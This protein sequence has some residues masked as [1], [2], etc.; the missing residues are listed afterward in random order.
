MY[1]FFF[2]CLCPS[3]P[4]LVFCQVFCWRSVGTLLR[5]CRWAYGRQVLMSDIAIGKNKM[6]FVTQD[7]E[8]FSGQWLGEYKKG[9]DKK[10][11]N[12]EKALSFTSYRYDVL[13]PVK[14]FDGKVTVGICLFVEVCSHSESGSVYE[15]IRLERLPYIHRAVSITMDSKG[16]NFGVLQSDPKTRYVNLKIIYVLHY[17]NIACIS[18]Y[19]V[20]F[21]RHGEH[22]ASV[23]SWAF[24]I[25]LWLKSFCN[26]NFL[27]VHSAVKMLVGK[28]WWRR[29]YSGFMLSQ[30]L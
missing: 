25:M 26:S 23:Q 17:M 7:G 5:Q 12:L 13:W 19:P 1:L 9:M 4:G 28:H 30:V 11:K 24:F 3:F 8:G 18:F 14:W 20:S 27:L 2:F 16:R 10:G 22:S 29:T 21:E 6:M 15:R